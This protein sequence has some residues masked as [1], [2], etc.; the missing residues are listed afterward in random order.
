MQ[1]YTSIA[2]TYP[3]ASRV[4][5]S[6]CSSMLRRE[7]NITPNNDGFR[8]EADLG[9]NLGEAYSP[10]LS[11]GPPLLP[12]EVGAPWFSPKI[13]PDAQEAARTPRPGEVR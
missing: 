11:A 9:P 7:C 8:P 2:R 10:L 6:S 3:L 4:A 5:K 13:T 1:H 12:A